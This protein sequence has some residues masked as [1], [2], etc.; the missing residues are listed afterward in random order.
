[1]N[2]LIKEIIYTLTISANNKFTEKDN[3]TQERVTVL[4]IDQETKIYLKMFGAETL[5]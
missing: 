4:L 3:T 5:E 2:Y 1:L